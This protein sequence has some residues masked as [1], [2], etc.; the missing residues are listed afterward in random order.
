MNLTAD[1]TCWQS[2]Q[3]QQK[4]FQAA[5]TK[6]LKTGQE[7]IH[8]VRWSP[9]GTCLA[10]G[11]ADSSLKVWSFQQANSDFVLLNGF[12]E[13]SSSITQLSWN[14]ANSFQLATASL[15]KTVLFWDIRERNSVQQLQN[16]DENIN[17]TWSPD[18]Q[19]VAVGTKRDHLKILDVRNMQPVWNQN[20]STEINEFGW[21]MSMQHFVLATGKGNIQVYDASSYMPLQAL[22]AHTSNCYCLEF[23]RSG[24]FF[25]TGGAD[26]V[27][28]VWD[29]KSFV[30]IQSFTSLSSPSRTLGFSHDGNCLAAGSEDKFLDIWRM[31]TGQSVMQIPINSPVNSLDWHPSKQL[32]AFADDSS[33]EDVRHSSLVKIFGFDS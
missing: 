15:D 20:F 11:S 25:A 29:C 31:E 14:P 13:H 18:G 22:N 3:K 23:D 30:P 17:I 10:S 19:Q 8:S 6:E 9:D 26:A 4:I 33:Q 16:D 28:L 32:V 5:K 27:I 12:R 24:R 1:F 7:K 2:I 21:S